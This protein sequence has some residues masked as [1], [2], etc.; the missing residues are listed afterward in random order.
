MADATYTVRE[1][2]P[3]G[4][5][6][7]SPGGPD[8][9]YLVTL[10]TG[11]LVSGKDFGNFQQAPTHINLSNSSVP[12]QAAVGSV[13]GNF[14]TVD[15]DAG[16]TFTYTLVSGAGSDDNASFTIVGNELRTAAMFDFETK[17]SY[18]IRVRTTD[19]GGLWHEEAFMIS[20]SDV[21]EIPPTVTGTTPSFATS[22]TLAAGTTSLQIS[23]SA[24]VLGGGTAGNYQ[25]QSLGSDALL[26]TGDDTIVSL[27][28]AYAGNTATL[29]FA[30]LP[31]SVYRLTVRATIANVAGT[32]LDGDDNGTAGGDWVSDFVV[33]PT[34]GD[35][36]YST[37]TYS[38]GGTYPYSVAIGDLNGDG[39]ADLAVANTGSGNV[40]VLLGQAGGTFLA[41][42]TYSSGGSAPRSVAIGDLNGDG[43]AD[44]AV[45][46]YGSGNVGVLL[47]QAGGT[48]AA[49]ATYSSGGSS[50]RSVAIGD[51]N[52][53]GRADL[54]VANYGSGNVGVLL[55]QAGGTF[56]AAA[57]YSSGGSV[58]MSVAIGDLNGDG[59]ADLAVAN[60]G[61]ETVGV[62]LGQAGG[63]FAAAA[64]YS[65]GGSS[66]MSVA[67]GDLNGDGRADLA[68]ANYGSGNV[69]VLLGQAG[70]TLAAAATYSS[71]GSYPMS[72]AIGDLN[73]DGR[74]DLAVAN[75]RQR[76]RGGAAGS[77]GRD[78]CGGGDVRLR[79]QLVPSRWRSGI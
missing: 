28:A 6:Q 18:A 52:G 21:S 43:R 5:M 48:F 47:G 56:A 54:A 17:A 14:T 26:G 69:G 72:V 7:T 38:S 59:R 71:G 19:A 15:R 22:G 13:V 62:L 35:L 27:A 36:L 57:T 63:T 51:L 39:R 37:P 12:E 2:L 42:A 64:T 44:L 16:D 30:A 65:S 74:A 31:E 78:V 68:V 11:E 10:A 3:Y 55:G 58:P 32:A 49:A 73:G 75:Y 67:I 40:G 53:D 1:V 76:Q 66:P 61:S 29:S 50:P 23:F 79:R 4:W 8:Y 25:L 46:N 45:A 70:G 60:S 24:P 33:L 41:A 9:R 77:G 20:V 34:G